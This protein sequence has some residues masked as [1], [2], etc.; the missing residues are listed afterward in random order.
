MLGIKS[1]ESLPLFNKWIDPK[2]MWDPWLDKT[3]TTLDSDKQREPFRAQWHQLVGIYK[4]L[5]QAF[6]GKSTLLMDAVGLGKTLQVVG[7]I[8]MLAYYR[9]AKAQTGDYPGGF[10]KL[11]HDAYG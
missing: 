5:L 4:M 8:A 1:G 11:D 7:V 9:E 6:E 10:S 2:G 3:P